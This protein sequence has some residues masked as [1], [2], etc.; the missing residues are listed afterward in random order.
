MKRVKRRKFGLVGFLNIYGATSLDNEC[1]VL[2]P[3]PYTQ[4]EE[5]SQDSSTGRVYQ[6]LQE[7]EVQGRGESS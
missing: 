1:R 5:N 4:N 6:L 3:S 7:A 2:T